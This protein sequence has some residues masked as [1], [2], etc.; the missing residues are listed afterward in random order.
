MSTYRRTATA[1][2]WTTSV[3]LRASPVHS[4]R[5]L[6]ALPCVCNFP[7]LSWVQDNYHTYTWG[8]T[9]LFSTAN[10]QNS[11]WEGLLYVRILKILNAFT[12]IQF[13]FNFTTQAR[14]INYRMN[15][16][17]LMHVHHNHHII[18]NVPHKVCLTS[19]CVW[20]ESFWVKTA[21][22]TCAYYK[23]LHHY[24]YFNVLHGYL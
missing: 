8:P 14:T 21:S 24:G 19:G 12:S 3:D 11:V 2:D 16:F 13:T 4:S 10:S 18:K 9:Y 6:P 1:W 15:I 5:L 23:P 17:Y 20:H 22:S 7:S